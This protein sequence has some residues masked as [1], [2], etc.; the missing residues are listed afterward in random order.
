M[1]S[2]NRGTVRRVLVVCVSTMLFLF[3]PGG[4]VAP[5]S[6]T[7][8]PTIT[9]T[10]S[11]GDTPNDLA[12]SPD[13]TQL[14]TTNGVGNSASIIDLRTSTVRAVSTGTQPQGVAITPDGTQAYISNYLSANV[15]VAELASGTILSTVAVGL[16]PGKGAFTGNGANAIIPNGGLGAN[17]ISSIDVATRVVTSTTGAT[18]P[19]CLAASP[20]GLTF[21][22]CQNTSLSIG[23]F[24]SGDAT[25]TSVAAGSGGTCVSPSYESDGLTLYVACFGSNYVAQ[26][27]TVTNTVVRDITVGSGPTATAMNPSGSR[28]FVLRRTAQTVSAIEIGGSVVALT[29]LV[30]TPL[31]IAVSNDGQYVLVTT[32]E[33]SLIVLDSSGTQVLQTLA[34]GGVPSSLRVSKTGNFA[35]ISL[36]DTDQVVI[37]NLPPA[38][39]TGLGVPTA[40]I[41]QYALLAGARCG[42]NPPTAVDFPGLFGMRNDGWSTSW[43]NWP[44]EG[45]GGTVC[46]RQ[47]F[48]TTTGTW[49]VR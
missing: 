22:I 25:V 23:F 30:G 49:G 40:S 13:G 16:L 20:D 21:F 17:T 19:G 4:P 42:E 15:S 34:L 44:N 48:Y 6:A 35:A 41:Q 12:I 7:E 27:D 33:G 3:A 9:A 37:V 43:A 2:M 18:L 8:L 39:A 38:A 11:V 5:A 29:S 26:I 28:L 32:Q 45:R 1:R 10:F 14:V 36:S 47:P 46:T 31:S 24:Q